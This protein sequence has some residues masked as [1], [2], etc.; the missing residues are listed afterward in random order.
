M[1]ENFLG[2]QDQWENRIERLAYMVQDGDVTVEQAES[3]MNSKPV[4]YGKMVQKQGSQSDLFSTPE[5]AGS[6][7]GAL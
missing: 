1:K 2:N 7:R 4:L 5:S 6:H 3:F